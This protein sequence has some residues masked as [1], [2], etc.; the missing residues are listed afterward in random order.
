MHRYCRVGEWEP[1][2]IEEVRG[3]HDVI[4]DSHILAER[5]PVQLEDLDLTDD[6]GHE[7]N[8]YDDNGYRIAR[9]APLYDDEHDPC[10]LLAD[11]CTIRGLFQK[12]D[13]F[14]DDESVI[15]VDEDEE[16]LNVNVYPQAL[17]Q[18]YGHFQANRVPANFGSILKKL[19]ETLRAEKDDLRPVI[20]GVACQGYNHIQN[21]LTERAGGLDVVHGQVT[22]A[23]AGV[24]T[25]SAKATRA[26]N[27]IMD[28][29]RNGLPHARIARK[30]GRDGV[31]SRDFRIEPVFVVDVQGLEPRFQT[32]RLAKVAALK[33]YSLTYF[34][35]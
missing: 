10:G 28:A 18:V 8:V 22:A 34:A 29:F 32:G 14:D 23:L 27:K 21:C 3:G 6:D 24:V 2:P 19:N 7:I 12:D 17:T 33:T 16:A 20:H 5:A 30:L 11:L 35:L 15:D 9:R 25:A 13:E 4:Y 26:H 31:L 1:L